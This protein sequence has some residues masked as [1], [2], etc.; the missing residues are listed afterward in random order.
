[1]REQRAAAPGCDGASSCAPCCAQTWRQKSKAWPWGRGSAAWKGAVC[2]QMRIAF[3]VNTQQ[4]F[5]FQSVH[6]KSFLNRAE[7]CNPSQ[8]HSLAAAESMLC[9][10]FCIPSSEALGRI[11]FSLAVSSP[12]PLLL[13]IFPAIAAAS[14]L[15]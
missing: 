4:R 14:L 9:C 12:N 13:Y 2:K 7:S 1:M 6:V 15:L 3:G 8:C 5:Q 11:L 10:C